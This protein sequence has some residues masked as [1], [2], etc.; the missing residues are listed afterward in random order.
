MVRN[1]IGL[2]LLTLLTPLLAAC[3]AS[4]PPV[5][6]TPTL[7]ATELFLQGAWQRGSSG[8]ADYAL[9]QFDRGTSRPATRTARET[10][11]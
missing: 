10:G 11:K 4:G 6:P 9:W 7:S 5:T 8:E 1:V 3:G 2:L